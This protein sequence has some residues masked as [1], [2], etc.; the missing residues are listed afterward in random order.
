M[1]IGLVRT[2]IETHSGLISLFL[3]WGWNKTAFDL[4]TVKLL[5]NMFDTDRNGTIGFAE[6][7]LS[8][9]SA[10]FD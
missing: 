3:F 6:V 8:V 4:D 10:E 2:N 1:E 5:M 9:L 7:R